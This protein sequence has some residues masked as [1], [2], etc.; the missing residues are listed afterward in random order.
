MEKQFSASI[1]LEE[2]YLSMKSL[3]LEGSLY[4]LL[5]DK[6]SKEEIDACLPDQAKTFL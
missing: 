1:C 2:L 5:L 4:S 3:I 6:F